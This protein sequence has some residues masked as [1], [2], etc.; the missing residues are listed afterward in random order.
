M[1]CADEQRTSSKVVASRL[2]R[3]VFLRLLQLL[4]SVSESFGFRSLLAADSVNGFSLAGQRLVGQRLVLD[5]R[6]RL[7]LPSCR[8]RLGPS[9]SHASYEI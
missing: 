1:D 7:A 9:L 2:C 5:C 3:L 6:M 8:M 4:M